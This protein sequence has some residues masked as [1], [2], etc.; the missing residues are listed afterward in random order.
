MASLTELPTPPA[1]IPWADFCDLTDGTVSRTSSRLQA[2]ADRL[3][4]D[5]WE[6]AEV[7]CRQ[8]LALRPGDRSIRNN[9]AVA[10]KELGRFDE[11]KLHLQKAILADAA[12]ATLHMN[13]ASVYCQRGDFEE[14]LNSL[15][16]AV[17]LDRSMKAVARCDLDF[18]PLFDT[19]EFVELVGKPT[20][21][22]QS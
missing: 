17:H 3:E 9:L 7:L 19:A 2:I 22:M 18:R 21:Q 14:A 13:L 16:R 6:L 8:E 20:L 12:C 5:D 4:E 15:R 10:L 1:S 11:A